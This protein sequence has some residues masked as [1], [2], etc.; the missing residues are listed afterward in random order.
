LNVEGIPHYFIINKNGYIV[1]PNS[2]DLSG[3]EEKLSA[4]LKE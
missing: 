1:Q 3:S 2:H 4:L